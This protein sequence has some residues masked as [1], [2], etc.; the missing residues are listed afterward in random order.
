MLQTHQSM[1]EHL[2]HLAKKMMKKMG[3]ENSFG[4]GYPILGKIMI[5]HILF[6]LEHRMLKPLYLELKQCILTQTLLSLILQ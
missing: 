4:L 2:S 3:V 1:L 6:G 5:T